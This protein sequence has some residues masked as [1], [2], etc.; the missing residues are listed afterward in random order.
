MGFSERAARDALR[1]SNSEMARRRGCSD[2]VFESEGANR[3]VE[4]SSERW[5]ARERLSGEFAGRSALLFA[6]MTGG[7]AGIGRERGF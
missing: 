3:V 5:E 1:C 2:G 6:V 7:L 4:S